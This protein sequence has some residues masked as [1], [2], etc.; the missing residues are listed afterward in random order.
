ML[1]HRFH[2]LLRSSI[3]RGMYPRIWRQ[4]ACFRRNFVAPK[5][6]VEQSKHNAL[7]R[8]YKKLYIAGASVL[9]IVIIYHTNETFR[10]TSRHAYFTAE[11]VA[12]VVLATVKCFSLYRRAL[13]SEYASYDEKQ[14]ALSE[15]HKRAAKI[16]LEALE[17]NGGIY[18]KLGQHVSALTYLLPREWTDTMIPLQDRCPQSSVEDIQR[19]F[20]RDLGMP[21]EEL[22][23]NFEED[24]VG[25]ASLAQVHIATLRLTGEKVAVKVQHPSLEEFIPI[26]IYMTQKVFQLMYKFFPEYPLTW[27]GDELQSSIFV[28]LNFVEEAANAERTARY[29][30]NYQKQTA[31]R[32]PR[33]ISANRRILIMEYVSGSRLDNHAYLKLH[34]IKPGEVSLCLS[35]IF[36]NMIFI[37]GVGLH[38]DPHGGNLAIRSVDPKKSRNGHNFEI[39]L[40]DHGLYRQIPDQM[41]HDYSRFWLALLDKDVPKMKLYAKK[42]AGIEGDQKFNIFASAITGRPPETALNYDITKK[43]SKEEMQRMQTHL[44]DEAGVL[45]D[46]MSILSTMP[47]IVLLILKTNDLT[48]NLDE[49]LQSPLG[50]ERTFLILA[51]YC[52]RSV[53][54]EDKDTIN[55]R[56]KRNSV[57]WLFK[58]IK[59]WC[60]FEWRLGSLYLFDLFLRMKAFL[61]I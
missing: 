36:N 44:H 16:T 43:R 40:Y 9:G 20:V 42:F 41:K 58:Q 15:T 10:A 53:Y 38:C 19:M 59:C 25:V 2:L 61:H 14:K 39:I 45:E 56:F 55:K 49:A 11:R 1:S 28:E 23:S 60:D 50:P 13:L 48:R 47:R 17:T 31:L 37:P 34:D 35:H 33:M 24:P 46:L 30:K 6:A 18:I 3:A 57:G 29:F 27:L 12:V 21:L 26:D 5:H 4:R 22:F 54:D 7:P 8:S 51:N 32:I 52:A